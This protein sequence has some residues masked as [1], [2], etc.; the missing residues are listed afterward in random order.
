MNLSDKIL[1]N[2]KKI[3]KELRRDKGLSQVEMASII[4]VGQATYSRIESGATEI[5]A[6]R[7]LLLC[8][9]FEINP[10]I[11]LNGPNSKS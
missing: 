2:Q 7:W 9:V 11:L 10:T 5:L 8:K 6:S 1:S 4:N 3:L